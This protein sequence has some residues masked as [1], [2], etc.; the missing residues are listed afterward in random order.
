MRSFSRFFLHRKVAIAL[1]VLFFL[2]VPVFTLAQAADPSASGSGLGSCVASFTA[3]IEC[4]LS[5]IGYAI[6]SMVGVFLAVVAWLFNV[7]IS[8]TVFEFA[9][10]F[11]NSAGI[12]AGWTVIRDISNIALLFGFVFIGIA[13]ILDIH[14]YEMKK[15]LPRLVIFAVLL[16]FSL[17]ASEAVIDGANILSSVLYQQSADRTGVVCSTSGSTVDNCDQEVGIAG[18]IIGSSKTS[19]LLNPKKFENIG[20]TAYLGLTLI[21]TVL[22][23]VLLAGAILLIVRAVTLVFLMVLSPIG[24]AGYAVP[25]LEPYAKR[26]WNALLSQSFFAPIFLVLVFIGLKIGDTLTTTTGSGASLGD[27]FT[28]GKDSVS[29]FLIFALVIGFMIAALMAA[30][31]LGAYGANFATNFA[32]KTV[33]GAFAP[34]RALSAWGGRSAANYAGS[35]VEKGYNRF[36]AKNSLLARGLRYTGADESIA[37]AIGKVKNVK[38]D[39]QSH[40]DRQKEYEHRTHDIERQDKQDDLSQALATIADA[41]ATAAT[42][43]AAEKTIDNL[44]QK[45]S[46][47]DLEEVIKSSSEEMVEALGKSMSP[48][49]YKKI[50]DSKEVSDAKKHQAEHGRFGR[51]EDD[52]TARAE[53]KNLT[54]E[55]QEMFAAANGER[56]EKLLEMQRNGEKVFKEEQLDVLKDSRN[57]TV[58]QN[59]DAKRSTIGKRVESLV[60][61]GRADDAYNLIIG[62]RMSAERKAK[63]DHTALNT[64]EVQ[65]TFDQKDLQ[66]LLDNKSNSLT[67]DEMKK[68]ATYARG[69]GPSGPVAPRDPGHKVRMGA[70][71]NALMTSEFLR[72]AYGQDH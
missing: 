65:A 50:M 21:E 30:K 44:T 19:T 23:V 53:F 24:F 15:T 12:I 60:D 38:I 55:D 8:Q 43:T 63:L 59:A 46:L 39:G 40:A 10:V 68:L 26:W 32:T 17:L 9:K 36:V 72:G 48:E 71:N 47:H 37:G 14:G 28:Q 64:V 6:F 34:A 1:W 35:R 29:V 58:A 41:S 54:K 27:L 16:N 18:E 52:D 61:A 2:A 66:A 3:P 4:I 49:R 56:F 13:T 42:K 51:F 69:Q 20:L 70:V 57:L 33:S 67:G 25:F 62:E 11:G 5:G 7:V 22:I 45:M 31:Q